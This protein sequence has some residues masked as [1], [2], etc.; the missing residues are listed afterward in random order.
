MKASTSWKQHTHLVYHCLFVVP[1]LCVCVCVLFGGFSQPDGERS[2]A[3]H[4][5]LWES[6][7]CASVCVLVCVCVCVCVCVSVWGMDACMCLLLCGIITPG[8]ASSSRTLVWAADEH[9]KTPS[10]QVCWAVIGPQ[11]L[12]GQS[13]WAEGAGQDS[14]TLFSNQ[15][16]IYLLPSTDESPQGRKQHRAGQKG[17]GGREGGKMMGDTP[18]WL[19]S[20]IECLTSLGV[21]IVG[22]VWDIA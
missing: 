6:V 18:R 4:Q 15:L 3:K 9:T 8:R 17:A 7:G 10:R 12:L 14:S 16:C 20:L 11:L 5:G 22:N 19:T 13:Y 21:N 1:E 2:G